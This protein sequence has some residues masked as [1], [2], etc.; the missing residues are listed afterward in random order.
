[1]ILEA[2]QLAK[3]AH[4]TQV[5]RFSGARYIEHPARV[6]MQV[7]LLRYADENMIAAAWLHDV[8]EDTRIRLD[9][10]VATTNQDVGQLVK[11]LTFDERELGDLTYDQRKRV[12]NAHVAQASFRA[13][14]I[15]ILDRLDNIQDFVRNVERGDCPLE[16]LTRYVK[17]SWELQK[18][19]AGQTNKDVDHDLLTWLR[20]T[21]LEINRQHQL[22]A[23]H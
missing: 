2:I 20:V 7:S 9:E 3:R 4:E 22:D 5:R 21:L 13:K 14:S 10:I 6:A 19:L 11:E 1:M 18:I 15:K 23:I 12:Q 8:L 16:K 17:T